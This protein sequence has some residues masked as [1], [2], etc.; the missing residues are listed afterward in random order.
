MYT[1]VCVRGCVTCVANARGPS[2]WFYCYMLIYNR[3]TE[4][5]YRI[6]CGENVIAGSS[7]CQAGILVMGCGASLF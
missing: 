2:Y 3:Q 6:S 4:V 5:R 1:I 7:R